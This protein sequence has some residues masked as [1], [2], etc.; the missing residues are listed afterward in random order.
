MAWNAPATATVGQVLTAAFLNAQM[1]DNF[2]AIDA[3]LDL[4]T[5]S[6]TDGG[7]LLGSGNGVITAMAVLADGAI[8]IGDGATDPVAL[9]AFSSSTGQLFPARGGTGLDTSGAATGSALIGT[10]SGLQ[11]NAP[12]TQGDAEAGTVTTFSAWSPERVKQAI[13]ALG[14]TGA[15]AYCQITAAGAL[16]ATSKNIASITDVGTGDRTVV[17]D[18]DFGNTTY[19]VA[20][21]LLEENITGAQSQVYN[22]SLAAGTMK[23]RIYNESVSLSDQLTSLV[24]LGDQ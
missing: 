19:S 13:A 24:A 16:A 14:D 20:H 8:V 17:W 22:S 10:G 1:R 21:A 9:A 18:T 7:V 23:H 5:S 11:I 4:A 2:L 6:F 3:L 15:T 12:V